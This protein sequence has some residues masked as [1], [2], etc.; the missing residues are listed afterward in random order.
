MDTEKLDKWWYGLPE[1][2]R[3]KLY[4]QEGADVWKDL[5]ISVRRALFRYC[6]LKMSGTAENGD[7]RSLLIE[8]ACGLA[9]AA[10]AKE[11][12]LPLEDMCDD[13]GGF[14]EEYQEQFDTIYDR[15]EAV[16]ASTDWADTCTGMEI[17]APEIIN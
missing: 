1:E 16:L 11:N 3:R 5:D 2:T 8:T 6:R 14:L 17:S 10:L 15:Y 12:A 9:D 7:T 13:E 4:V